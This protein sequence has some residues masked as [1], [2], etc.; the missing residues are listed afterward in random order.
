[1]LRLD[2]HPSPNRRTVC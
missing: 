2:R 1:M